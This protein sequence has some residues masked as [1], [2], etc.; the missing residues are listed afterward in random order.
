[1]P[2]ITEEI[3]QKLIPGKYET[4][5]LA[6]WPKFNAKLQ[7][8][9]AEAQ[10]EILQNTI[11]AIR[12]IRAEMNVPHSKKCKAI[13]VAQFAESKVLEASTE[14]IKAL[15]ATDEIEIL[16][17]AKKLEQAA[18][19]VV[20]GV[21]IYIPLAGLIDLSKEKERLNKV[22][23]KLEKELA[24]LTQRLQNKNFVDK[25]PKE[26]VAEAKT[27]KAELAQE[28]KLIKERV[29]TLL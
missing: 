5:V 19:A 15:A 7:N 17:K 24:G 23:A 20:P 9:E 28:I 22:A 13:F 3:Y 26:A 18:S 29:K 10:I 12:N 4:I 27:R 16:S 25:A 2:F 1:M 14:Y 8:E 11:R 21:Q 6:E